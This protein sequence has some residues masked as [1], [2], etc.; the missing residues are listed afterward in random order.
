MYYWIVYFLQIFPNVSFIFF[1]IAKGDVL[2]EYLSDN[3][4]RSVSTFS[5]LCLF[6]LRMLCFF[7]NLIAFHICWSP[8]LNINMCVCVYI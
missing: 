5:Y 8:L 7:A 3:F 2:L 6:P 1:N 4:N